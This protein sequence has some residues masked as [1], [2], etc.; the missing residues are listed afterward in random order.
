M[1]SLFKKLGLA[2]TFS[3]TGKALLKETKRLKDI[4][5]AELVLIHVGEKNSN[6]EKLLAETINLT[7]INPDNFEIIWASGDPADAII[8]KSKKAGV[9]LL[10]AGAL[11]KEK[12]IKYYLGSVARKIMREASCSSLILI[13]PSENPKPF[14]KFFVS[15]DFSP[16]SERTI[17]LTY[18]FAVLE[19]A[20]EFVIVRD[21]E[22]PGLANT[23]LDSVSLDELETVKNQWR[24]EEEEK[25]KLFIKE[26]NLKGINIKTR[27]LY[28]KEGWEASNF[29]KQNNADIFAVTAPQKR[30]KLVDRLF[31]HQLEYSFEN[32]PSNLLIVR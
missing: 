3:P 32:L 5:N 22:T 17:K 26:L 24:T 21:Y 30:L 12:L 27:C 16:E 20:E 11:E 10:I 14:K 18:G 2:I 15:T 4:F 25:M 6:T 29:A 23:I 9:D 8:S 31:H 28:G 1:V 19:Q 7:G 13:E